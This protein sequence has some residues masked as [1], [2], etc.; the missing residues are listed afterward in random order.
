MLAAF[1]ASHLTAQL[2][3][4]CYWRNKDIVRCPSRPYPCSICCSPF[5]FFSP[6]RRYMWC[7]ISLR[8]RVTSQCS[9]CPLD[10]PGLVIGR[11]VAEAS[12]VLETMAHTCSP[13]FT[14]SWLARSGAIP[15]CPF[16][17]E[18]HC[19]CRSSSFTLPFDETF[20]FRV[21]FSKLVF[22]PRS[23]VMLF[24]SCWTTA[25]ACEASTIGTT[26]VHT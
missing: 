11:L 24:C 12:S 8:S 1:R 18:M 14:T 23:Y 26:M 9:V 6:P 25:V 2:S 7:N 15:H 16:C 4:Q 22:P 17:N 10:R 3:K 20:S 13:L 5:V 19:C 21:A